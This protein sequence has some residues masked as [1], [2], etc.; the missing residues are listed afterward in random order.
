MTHDQEEA[1]AISD[2]IAV[3]NAG[4]IQHIGRPREIYQRPKNV[5]VATFIEE[6]I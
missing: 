3:M 4:V 2:K 1:M 6:P 5:F